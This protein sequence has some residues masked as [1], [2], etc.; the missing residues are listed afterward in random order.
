M[1]KPTG[2]VVDMR[3]YI[4]EETGDLPDVIPERIVSLAIFFGAIVAWSPTTSRTVTNTRT[5]PA[6]AVLA[7]AD[8]AATSSRHSTARRDTSSGNARSAVTT[9]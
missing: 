9:A 7:V 2:W 5:C 3:H 4:D 1:V 8:V 6:G